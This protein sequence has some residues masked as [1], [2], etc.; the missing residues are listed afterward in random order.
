MRKYILFLNLLMV[1]SLVSCEEYLDVVP[2]NVTT[3]GD[4]FNNRSSAER[5]LAT[6][7]SY[8]PIAGSV[9]GDPA[10]LS[11]DEILQPLVF[12]NLA[13]VRIQK[14]FQNAQNPHFDRWS[15][16]ESYYRAIRHC[17]EFLANINSVQDIEEFEREQWIG[18]VT[19]LKAYY[20]F[21]LIQM[22]GPV[23]IN[24][25]NIPVSADTEQVAPYRDLVDEAFDYIVTLLDEAIELLPELLNPD[26]YGRVYK[27]IASAIKAKVLVTAAS[28]LFNGN[29]IFTD[30]VN[31]EGVHY[32]NQTFD[33][34]KW[35]KAVQATS[36]A[37]TLC[38]SIGLSLYDPSNYKPRQPQA[39]IT[40]LKAGLRGRVT[41]EWNEE[42]IW[43]SVESSGGGIQRESMPKLFFH[44]RVP[45]LSNRGVTLRIAELFYSKNGVPIDEDPDWDYE[46]RFALRQATEEEKYFVQP[47]QTTVSLHF[48]R[49][50]RFYADLA[51][52]RGT[53]FGNGKENTDEAWYVNG[54]FNEYGSRTEAYAYS[55]SG[56]FPKK[57]VNIKSTVNSNGTSF[58]VTRYPFPILR[59]SDLYLLHAE[60]LNESKDAPDT[61][62]YNAIDRI[63][64]RSGL[65]G[66][67]ESWQN[68]SVNSDKP[69]TKEGMRDIIR[70]ERL[71]ELAF[72]GHRFWD[73]RRWLLARDILNTPLRGWNVAVESAAPEDYYQIKVLN[74]DKFSRFEE[75]DYLWPIWTQEIIQTPSLKQN[76]GWR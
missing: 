58:A 56:Y 2:D 54:R 1:L 6:T 10:V 32:F 71:I 38:E 34:S 9:A 5:Y 37:I 53:W 44:T 65:N 72:E 69:K 13:G 51:F 36:E 62:V 60:A 24:Y 23:V 8:L 25:E 18:E 50:P 27:P 43:G 73:L 21:L 29:S 15:G 59:L 4:L 30:F 49:E 63:R 48:D 46:N 22:Y 52:D 67:V 12:N 11:G 3:I 16:G 75:K 70:Q 26:D 35:D 74:V 55:L 76:P 7:Y 41:D 68:H 20:H 19:F 14:G 31:E 47:G 45:V 64:K 57:L 33:Q 42:L 66:V 28:P 40:L 39:D 61:E 17:N